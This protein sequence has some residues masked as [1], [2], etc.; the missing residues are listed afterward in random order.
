MSVAEFRSRIDDIITQ[1]LKPLPLNFLESVTKSKLSSRIRHLARLGL[2]Y[3]TVTMTHGVGKGLLFNAG[4]ASFAYAKGTSEVPVQEA[5]E[6]CLNTGDIFYDIG[7]N[8]GFFTIIAAKLVGNTGHVY[9]FEPAPENASTIRNNVQINQF[10]HVT[11]L[12]KAVSS[13]SGTGKLLLTHDPGGNTLATAGSPPDVKGEMS[14]ELVSI[15]DLVAQGGV[16]PPDVVKVDVE[17]AEVE[18]LQGMAQT[19]KSFQ[20]LIIYEIDDESQADFARKQTEVESL[21]LEF[22]YD[23][24]P[25]KDSYPGI[26]WNVG[27]AIATPKH[28]NQSS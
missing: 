21:L 25:L 14:T 26:P 9:A 6:S 23:I 27:H 28:K 2:R 7:A 20:P 8:V 24:Q 16:K 18:V 17:G 11:V 4:K 10:P 5:L 13:S 12:E 1:I 15:D 22:D 3:R 19:I